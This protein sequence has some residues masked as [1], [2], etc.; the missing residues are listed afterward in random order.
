MYVC[1]CSGGLQQSAG[2]SAS[3]ELAQ[4]ADAAAPGAATVVSMP[5][6]CVT[7]LP[8]PFLQVTWFSP[9]SSG[10]V[11]VNATNRR[12]RCLGMRAACPCSEP[13]APPPALCRYEGWLSVVA[14]PLER[15][16]LWMQAQLRQA[17]FPNPQ[18]RASS[19]LRHSYQRITPL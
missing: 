15:F 18:V 14:D 13:N 6:R 10:L 9:R 17:N 11:G 5:A 4:V 19:A 1:V 16:L 12:L 2:H 7:P 8:L 3:L